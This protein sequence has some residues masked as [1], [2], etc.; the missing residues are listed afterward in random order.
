M[1]ANR[2]TVSFWGD[3]NYEIDYGCGCT[4]LWTYLK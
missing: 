4:S 1:T 3:E 2:F